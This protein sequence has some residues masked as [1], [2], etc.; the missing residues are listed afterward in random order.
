MASPTEKPIAIL[1][2]G[3]WGTALA[4]YLARQGQIVHLW[5]E[6]ESEIQAL[7]THRVNQQFLPG[8]PLPNTICPMANLNQA[9]QDVEAILI[10]IPSAGFRK[11]ITLLQTAAPAGLGLISATK[12]MDAVHGQLLHE[13][14]IDILGKT[15]PLAILSGPT[16]AREVAAGLPTAAVMA[17]HHPDFLAILGTRFHSPHFRIDFSDDLVG[18]EVG[19]IIKN[20][21]AI[22]AGI[23]DG[24][25]LGANARA[26]L[27][28]RG[29]GEMTQFGVAL[30]ARSETFVGLSGLGDLIL[31]AMDDQSRNRRLGLAL[32]HG[33]T[34]EAAEKEIGQAIEGKQNASFA[35]TRAQDLHVNLPLC[36]KVWDILQ[37]KSQARELAALV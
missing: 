11:I 35:V 20:I 29:F 22:A 34:I 30:G 28:T 5:S 9:L 3:S 33:K 24:M 8:F 13:V 18:V 31:T 14:M 32:G 25:Q 10:A 19:S 21:I 37:G 15:R 2:A 7:L 17:S 36:E 4:L 1:G 6:V 16:F 12:G 27:I 23:A 26:S